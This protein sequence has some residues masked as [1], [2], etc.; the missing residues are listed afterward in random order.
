MCICEGNNQIP[1]SLFVLPPSSSSSL[2]FSPIHWTG[3]DSL[4]ILDNDELLNWPLCYY[5][6]SSSTSSDAQVLICC[7]TLSSPFFSLVFF[8]P[9]PSAPLWSFFFPFPFLFLSLDLSFFPA[10]TTTSC[11]ISSTTIYVSS[12]CRYNH[13]IVPTGENQ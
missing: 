13:L 9:L 4:W 11:H 2:Y 12:L 8:F 3:L 7:W 1:P 5:T 6:Y 10:L